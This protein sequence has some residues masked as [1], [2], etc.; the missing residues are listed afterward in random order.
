MFLGRLCQVEASL[1]ALHALGQAADTVPVVNIEFLHRRH[2]AASPGK[3]AF[4]NIEP[5]V[6]VLD[7]IFNGIDAAAQITQVL[8]DNFF[9]IINH[10]VQIIP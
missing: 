6:M 9:G 5:L 10:N 7:D 3:L 2:V 4:Q 8:K 1:D